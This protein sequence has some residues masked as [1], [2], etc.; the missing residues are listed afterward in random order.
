MNGC[1]KDKM[2]NTHGKCKH[3]ENLFDLNAICKRNI[4]ENIFNR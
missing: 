3:K 1:F 4:K 2:N